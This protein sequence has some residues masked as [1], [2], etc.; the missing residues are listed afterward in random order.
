MT[1]DDALKRAREIAH[2]SWQRKTFDNA[3]DEIADALI[4]ASQ[5]HAPKEIDDAFDHPCKE[6]C[7]GWKQGFERGAHHA[8]R[9]GLIARIEEM[10][11]SMEIED[12]ARTWSTFAPKRIAQHF[13]EG[14]LWARTTLRKRISGEGE[15]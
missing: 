9:L 3:V 11:P 6:T 12:A 2:S 5:F 14:A 15:K 10:M 1:R 13:Y 4:E 8:A 7:S